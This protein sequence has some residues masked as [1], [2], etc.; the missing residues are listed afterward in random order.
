MDM[1]GNKSTAKDVENIGTAASR[2]FV[3]ITI[4]DP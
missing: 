4:D 2:D 1:E 3:I